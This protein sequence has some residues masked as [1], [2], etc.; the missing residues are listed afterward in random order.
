M[1]S[2]PRPYPVLAI[3]VAAVS[4][5]AIFIRLADAPGLVVALYRMLIASLLLLPLSLRALRSAALTGRTLLYS[6]LAGLF[7]AG[8]FATWI[9]SLSYTSVSA[10]VTLVASQP[11]WVA[12][13][14]WLFLGLA[15]SFLVLLGALVAVAGGALIGFGDFGGGSAPLLGDGLALAGALFA[16]CY[17]LLGRS[18][19]RRGLA[20]RHYI[21]LAYPFAALVLLPLPAL[22]G[23]PYLAYGPETFLWLALLALVPQLIGHTSINYA[24]TRLPPTLVATALLLEPVGASAAALLLFGERPSFTTLLGGALLLLGVFLGV[25]GGRGAV[26][27]AP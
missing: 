3:G 25:Q 10:S 5:A 24:M 27:R 2:T 14:S 15:P 26:V 6:L 19:Q 7:L 1:P 12:V 8:H 20:L 16:A 22:A 11:L 9:S 17:L 21:G 4:L 23:L 18:A 13:L